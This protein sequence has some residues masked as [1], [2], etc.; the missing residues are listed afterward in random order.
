MTAAGAA[1]WGHEVIGVERHEGRLEALLAGQVPFHEPAL[2]EMLETHLGDGRLRF[3]ADGAN[4]AADSSLVF[5]AVGTVNL[6]Q[7]G[8]PT[9]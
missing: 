3:S 6:D 2:G 5:V 8:K 1:E 9:W 4:A 7:H